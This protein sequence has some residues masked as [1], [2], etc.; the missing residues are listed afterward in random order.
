MARRF[1]GLRT[2]KRHQLSELLLQQRA[3]TGAKLPTAARAYPKSKHDIVSTLVMANGVTAGKWHTYLHNQ[4]GH[5]EVHL[6]SYPHGGADN[7][8]PQ[9]ENPVWKW[10]GEVCPGTKDWRPA[11]KFKARDGMDRPALEVCTPHRHL[12]CSNSESWPRRSRCRV[13]V[14]TQSHLL[15]L[16]DLLRTHD[17][18][19]LCH[20]LELQHTKY[21][22]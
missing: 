21:E 19:K 18:G 5:K 4:K 6:M 16:L 17:S 1:P 11:A 10:A 12:L 9:R 14:A 13:F 7:R 15:C 3:A 2:L 22:M 8:V 20:G